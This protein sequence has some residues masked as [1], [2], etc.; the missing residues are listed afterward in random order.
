MPKDFRMV[1]HSS[2][3]KDLVASE[4]DRLNGA[5]ERRDFTGMW[6]AHERIEELIAAWRVRVY[7]KIAMHRLSERTLQALQ[8]AGLNEIDAVRAATDDELL[9]IPNFGRKR[10]KELA[11]SGLRK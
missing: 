7:G 2:E 3:Y 5:V 9:A 8:A 10:L 1:L 6:Q 11:A 4:I